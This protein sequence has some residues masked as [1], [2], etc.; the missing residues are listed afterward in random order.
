MVASGT[1]RATPQNYFSPSRNDVVLLLPALVGHGKQFIR[2]VVAVGRRAKYTRW[3][4]IDLTFA[5]QLPGRFPFKIARG[6]DEC[7]IE[8][9]IVGGEPKM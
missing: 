2:G 4:S 7:G 3:V 8:S 1:L 6:R 5:V 9:Q